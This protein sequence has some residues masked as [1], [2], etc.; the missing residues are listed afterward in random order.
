MPVT[1]CSPFCCS[2]T[3]ELVAA[4]PPA[5]PT[6]RRE[7]DGVRRMVA[8]AVRQQHQVER[9][10]SFGGFRARGVGRRSTGRRSGACRRACVN[11]NVEW[12]S[13]R[14]ESA[15]RGPI[16]SCH[17]VKFYP[18]R[19]GGHH[20]GVETEP[21]FKLSVE[22]VGITCSRRA[23]PAF[24]SDDARRDPE[25]RRDRVQAPRLSR[26]HRRADRGGARDEEGQSLLLLPQ[27]GRDPVRLSSVLARSA[28]RHARR[29]RAE[30]RRRPTR[31]C[32]S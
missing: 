16:E 28:A 3:R 24:Q 23:A 27:Q 7:R 8:V 19:R 21:T 13:Q 1:F 14:N 30:R 6:A 31:S 4:R 15:P 9:A 32:G 2:H 26:R 10:D 12:P 5:R 22:P 11:R 17:G 29:D 25:E 20:I 18:M